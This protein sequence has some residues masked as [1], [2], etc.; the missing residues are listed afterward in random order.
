[1]AASFGGYPRRVLK[2]SGV[3]AGVV[4]SATVSGC[5]GS[6][7]HATATGPSSG[8]TSAPSA[9]SSVGV[10]PLATAPT[11]GHTASTGAPQPAPT[12]S[13]TAHPVTAGPGSKPP[14]RPSG[15]TRAG[16]YTYDDWGSETT[17][18]GTQPASG[19]SSLAEDAPSGS[20]Q[21]SSESN[22]RGSQD[23]TLDVRTTGL[24]VTDI[25][26]HQQ[27][28]DEDFHPIGTA[29]YFPADYRVGRSWK[30]AAQS[31]DGKYR[32]DVSTRISG[33]SSVTVQRRAVKTLVVDSTLHITGS[34]FDVTDTQRDW[35]STAYALIVKEHAVTSGTAEGFAVSSDV[36]RVLRSTTPS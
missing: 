18:L 24:Y 2:V 10:A 25:A 14:G 20:H 7:P 12:A 30:W 5:G 33:T 21:H 9:S 3:V 31:T 6:S 17:P 16:T 4:L 26:I 8:A 36:T 13:T 22:S 35:V 34:G 23:L 32:I 28:F 1:M 27:G 29:L 19:T 11:Q 15:F